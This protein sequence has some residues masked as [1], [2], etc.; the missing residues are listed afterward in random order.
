MNATPRTK[1]RLTLPLVLLLIAIGL[2][3]LGFCATQGWVTRGAPM[4]WLLA[5][6]VSFG[7]AAAVE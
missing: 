1:L 7:G 4:A 5:G 6:L 2:W 3:V